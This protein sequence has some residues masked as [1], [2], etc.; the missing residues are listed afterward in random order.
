MTRLKYRE[1]RNSQMQV[2]KKYVLRIFFK[3]VMSDAARMAGVDCSKQ[4]ILLYGKCMF[5]SLVQ[6]RGT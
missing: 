3:R 6:T 5:T 1:T 2:L 4:L